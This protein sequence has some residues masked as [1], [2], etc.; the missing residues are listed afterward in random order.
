MAVCA[1]TGASGYV[2]SRISAALVAA[3]WE[4]RPLGRA[5]GFRLGE[6]PDL[7][8]VDALVHA[9]WD[10]SART[11]AEIE[12]TNV[13]GSKRVLEA[14]CGRRIVFVSTLSAFPGARSLYGQA[15]LAVEEAARAAGGAVIRPGLVWSEEG[16]SLYASLRKLAR[17]PLLPTFTDRKLHPAH[18]DDV[19]ALVGRLLDE[20]CTGEP[21]VAA[22]RQPLT[23][24]QILRAA[25]PRLRIVPV[26]WRLVWAPL[27]ALELAGL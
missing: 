22:A 20:P 5:T 9:A 17:L 1:V 3:G 24:S 14:A 7:D 6:V 2:G 26:P 10:F 23:L 27:R 18:V 8:G 15:K 13:E 19:A 25:N 12:R 16:G 21:I 11:Q 4:V